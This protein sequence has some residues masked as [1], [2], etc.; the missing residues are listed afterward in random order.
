[1]VLSSSA[2]V[3]T[4]GQKASRTTSE[5]TTFAP[6]EVFVDHVLSTVDWLGETTYDEDWWRSFAEPS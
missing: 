1:M 2:T 4:C 5:T 3:C 6:P